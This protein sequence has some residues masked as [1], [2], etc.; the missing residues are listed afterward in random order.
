[1]ILDATASYRAMWIDKQDPDTVYMDKRR[2]VKPDI[3]CVWQHLPFKDGVFKTVNFDPPHMLY[4]SKGKPMGF[5]FAEKFGVLEPE[6]WQRDLREAFDEFMRVLGPDETL[7]LKWNDNHIS[8]SRMLACLPFKPKFGSQVRE[9]KGVR[10][11][12]SNDP[13]SVTSWFFFSKPKFIS[14]EMNSKEQTA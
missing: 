13:R 9:S 7:L 5:N 1:M 4:V 12:G 14:S 10:R 2:E 3:I 11:K 6:T 8:N